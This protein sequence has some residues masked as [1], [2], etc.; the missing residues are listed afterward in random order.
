VKYKNI[1]KIKPNPNHFII[2]DKW[3]YRAY[4]LYADEIFDYISKCIDEMIIESTLLFPSID[5]INIGVKNKILSIDNDEHIWY[6][7][8]NN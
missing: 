7:T 4:K 5:E 3:N 2:I 1:I 6:N 8:F